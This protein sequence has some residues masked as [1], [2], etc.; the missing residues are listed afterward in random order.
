MLTDAAQFFNLATAIA[1][2]KGDMEAVERRLKNAPKYLQAPLAQAFVAKSAVNMIDSEALAAKRRMTTAFFE[3]LRT[4]SVFARLVADRALKRIPLRTRIAASTYAGVGRTI[5]ETMP[6]PVMKFTLGDGQLE[7]KKAIAII[8]V[9][10]EL[11]AMDESAQ[12]INFVTN[13]TKAAAA[14]AVD[15]DFVAGIVD[16]NTTVIPSSGSSA[17][18]IVSD[19]AQLTAAINIAGGQIYFIAGTDAVKALATAQT[20]TGE[21]AFPSVGLQGGDLLNSPL[22]VCDQLP[23]DSLLLINAGGITGDLEDADL[24]SSNEAALEFDTDPATGAREQV[25]LWQTDSVALLCEIFFA[26]EKVQPDTVAMLTGLT[27]ALPQS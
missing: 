22:L 27:P 13:E 15:A 8:V 2:K 12:A 14:S 25:S 26:Y 7:P 20:V 1:A 24:R 5:A 9:S 10:E 18:D 11:V 21:L 17:P 4:E 3:S 16:S 6:K 23:P 19:L